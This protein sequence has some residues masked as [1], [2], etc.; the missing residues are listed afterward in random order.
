MGYDLPVTDS[1]VLKVNKTEATTVRLETNY[2]ST[3]E[4][5]D[6]A[7]IFEAKAVDVGAGTITFELSGEPER[8]ADFLELMR[9]YGIVGL[10]KSG[11]IALPKDQKSGPRRAKLRTA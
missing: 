2:R 11:R 9:T 7:N 4:I 5:L 8:L 1:R 3:Q 6:A 10:A